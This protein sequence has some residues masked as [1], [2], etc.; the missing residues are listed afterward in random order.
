MIWLDVYAG[1]TLQEA[2]P[3]VQLHSFE[4]RSKLSAAGDWAATAPAGDLRSASLL[5]AGRTALAYRMTPDGVEFI[6]GGQITDVRTRIDANGALTLDVTGVDLLAEMA[7]VTAGYVESSDG[8][9]TLRAAMPA[10]WTIVE[11]D[12]LPVWTARYAHDS[13][14]AAWVRATERAGFRFRL[15]PSGSTIRR[16]Q[17][18]N[19][20]P[21]SGVRAYLVADP[22]A[23]EAV[24]TICLLRNIEEASSVTD[25]V[26]RM[27][28][29]GA[30]NW[31]TRLTL[32]L[33]TQWP[34]GAAP[35]GGYTDGAG[36]TFTVNLAESRL[37]CTSS[38]TAYGVR[39]AAIQFA[40][41]A[42]LTN[43]TADMNSA[44]N[45]L[46]RAACLDM[47]ARAA[48]QYAYRLE[49]AG[50]R[51][52]VLP[53]DSIYVDAQKWVDGARPINI[54]RTL[55]V[56]DTTLRYRDGQIE[57]GLTVATTERMPA[58]DAGAVA[59]AIQGAITMAA[60]PQAST[61]V[62]TICASDAL[63]DD[64]LAT[65][66]FW[67]GDEA[68]RIY[69][70]LMR[71]RVDPLRSTAKAVGGSASGTVDLPDHTHGVTTN[72]HTHSVTVD[73][74]DHGVTVH[75]MADPTSNGLA[76]IVYMEPDNNRFTAAFG[77]SND[78]AA[79]T[80]DGGGDTVTSASG[81]G[82]TVTSASG[83]ATVGTTVDISSALTLDYGIFEESG[84]NTYAYSD[85]EWTANGDAVTETPSAIGSGWYSLDLTDY[86]VAADGV[87]P[88][89]AANVVT[90]AIKTASEAGKTCQVTV[91]IERRFSVQP[92]AYR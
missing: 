88:A 50:L 70:I 37:D 20:T 17:L 44:A 22:V 60:L 54:Q 56:L 79:T 59:S 57:H 7:Q 61:T 84:A 47:A 13:V 8:E 87:R 36:N 92:I 30:G 68:G 26:N 27:Y 62:D 58:S 14:L 51:S 21:A 80:E 76:R 72:N 10:G 48:A 42:P 31:E 77:D 35:G 43:S 69:Q 38:Q 55:T 66:R 11:S 12:T 74:H 85:L 4:A 24:D 23:V 49:V 39:A 82:Q 32:A 18:L 67:L 78:E 46:L 15:A 91:Q 63:D 34:N 40:D 53:G 33:A 81:G 1:S 64:A 83:G 65:F 73:D 3:V 2:G 29:Y 28:V 19:S 5:L 16:M 45:A 6:G 75:G 89:A 41:I 86:V 90:V 71:Y 9:T 52:T 25:I